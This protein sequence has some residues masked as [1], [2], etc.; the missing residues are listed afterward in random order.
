M[1]LEAVM[2]WMREGGQRAVRRLS[3][4]AWCLGHE[5]EKG[6]VSLQTGERVP[7]ASRTVGSNTGCVVVQKNIYDSG[8]NMLRC[9]WRSRS[10]GVERRFLSADVSETM[11]GQV[12]DG[13]W[14]G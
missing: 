11:L 8:E 5:R 4:T 3:Q 13:L 12:W 6:R 10:S 1:A 2:V 14:S 7:V 9:A